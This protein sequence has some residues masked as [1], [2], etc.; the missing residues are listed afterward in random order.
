[1]TNNSLNPL[2]QSNNLI[3]NLQDNN[4]FNWE[5]RTLGH[6]TAMGKLKYITFLNKK[7]GC[8]DA[9]MIA[10]T[11]SKIVHLEFENTSSLNNCIAR[12]KVLCNGLHDMTSDNEA[13]HLP[14]NVHPISMPINPP[15]DHFHHII[16][17]LFSNSTISIK[18]VTDYSNSEVTLLENSNS[19]E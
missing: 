2:N 11:I 7:Q 6:L 3:P 16:Q 17:S 15:M 1:M 8:Y 9:F 12:N 13:F 18:Q 5:R 4:F 14:D 19:S 10:S